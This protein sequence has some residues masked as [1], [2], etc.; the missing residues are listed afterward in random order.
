M[1][2]TTFASPLVSLVSALAVVFPAFSQTTQE[3]RSTPTSSAQGELTQP[4]FSHR[5]A[6]DFT[7]GTTDEEKA[8]LRELLQEPAPS[9]GY[10]FD[11]HT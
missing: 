4:I 7:P 10:H 6:I 11:L 8:A 5:T 1:N 9:G 2:P 3:G